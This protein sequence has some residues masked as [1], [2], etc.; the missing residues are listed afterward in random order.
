MDEVLLSK[1]RLGVLA[2]LLPSE[3]VAFSELQRATAATNG[4]LGAHLAKLTQAGYV[5]E[6]KAFVDRRP[7]TR[8]R[9]TRAGRNAFLRH[10]AELQ[11]L[12]AAAR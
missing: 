10:V 6:E 1:V 7:Q 8:Y 9:L 5:T 4:N 11:A 2:E 12:V 3:W